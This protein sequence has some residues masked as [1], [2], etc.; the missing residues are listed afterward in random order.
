M[1]VFQAIDLGLEV[2]ERVHLDHIL[3]TGTQDHHL[4]TLEL[5]ALRGRD[6]R[7]FDGLC[8]ATD[9]D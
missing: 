4:Y 1:A 3:D 5:G 9:E 8:A 2:L 6:S 7:G